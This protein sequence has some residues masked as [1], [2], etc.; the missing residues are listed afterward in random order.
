MDGPQDCGAFFLDAVG[1]YSPGQLRVSWSDQIRPTLPEVEAFIEASWLR[2][3][4]EAAVAG[5]SLWDGPLCRL[6]DY[7]PS[8]RRLDMTLGPTGYRDF[9]GTNLYNAHLRYT[10][11]PE[12]LA[13]PIGVSAIIVVRDRFLL[14]GRR[15]RA[16]AYH[17]ERIHPFGGCAEPTGNT[18]PPDMFAS[19][20]AELRQELAIDPDAIGEM[21][22]LGMVRDKQIVQPELVFDAPV[23]ISVA[24]IRVRA[25]NADDGREHTDILI[26][27]DDPA[28][29]VSFIELN[30][31]DLTPVALAGLLLHGLHAW[32]TGWFAST[33]GYLRT[34]I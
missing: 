4:A 9:L 7:S 5:A 1:P 16:V 2:R 8:P 17:P 32:G 31:T 21:L 14:L 34:L 29:V 27:R 11:G 23:N 30:I 12:M 18:D 10:H 6:I 13:S 3:A 33:R 19:L 15:S 28:S 25:G 20:A 22:C 24:D 26:V